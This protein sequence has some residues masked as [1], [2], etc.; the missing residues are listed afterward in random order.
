MS[1]IAYSH[2]RISDLTPLLLNDLANLRHPHA[3]LCEHIA[4]T[5]PRDG[6]DSVYEGQYSV[7]RGSTF[8]R[9]D[10]TQGT[11]AFEIYCPACE[12]IRGEARFVE[13]FW[14]K[15]KFHMMDTH[16]NEAPCSLMHERVTA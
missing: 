11:C 8:T 6:G 2:I 13:Y 14:C 16:P 10:G 9:D 4:Q 15:G 5:T 7:W 1:D 3:L 12:A